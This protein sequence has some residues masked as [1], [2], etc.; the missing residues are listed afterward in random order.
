MTSIWRA[1]E[2]LARDYQVQIFA[3]THNEEMI[4]Y[5]F[6]A[7]KNNPDTFRYHRLEKRLRTE[8]IEVTTYSQE[9]MDAAI[10]MD[11]EVR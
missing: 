6:A 3:T 11:I 5:A 10:E 8:R 2:K 4:R 7:F 9:T 1:I